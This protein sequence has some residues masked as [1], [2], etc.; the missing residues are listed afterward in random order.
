MNRLRALLGELGP[1]RLGVFEPRDR[2]AG[3][4]PIVGDEVLADV[5]LLAMEVHCREV[6]LRIEERLGRH[7]E[8]EA[9]LLERLL[10]RLG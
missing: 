10:V 2:V 7:L 3:V 4:A 5:D 8:V 9:D 6:G 1:D